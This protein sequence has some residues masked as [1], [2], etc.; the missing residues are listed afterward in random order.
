MVDAI[1]RVVSSAAFLSGPV[2]PALALPIVWAND[3]LLARAALD[4]LLRGKRVLVLGSGPSA[5]DLDSIPDDVVVVTCKLAPAVLTDKNLRRRVDLYY[6]P[7]LRV[8][9]VGRERR[10]QLASL[11]R[12]VSIDLLVCEDWLTLLDVL[13][14][15]PAYSRLVMDFTANQ[16]LLR[17]LIAPAKVKDIRGRSYCPWTSTGVR[18]IQYAVSF[19]AREIFVIGID[20]GEKGYASGRAM[21]SWHHEDIDGNF[22]RILSE[23]H[24]HLYSLSANSPVAEYFPVRAWQAEPTRA[25]AGT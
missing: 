13:P 5:A 7:N 8:D 25:Q 17:Q 15:R 12:Q 4:H 6:Y 2:Y 24:D 9:A 19:G 23:R 14:L 3:R 16:R 22:L 18:L 20:L 1:R 21:R 11:V 10:A